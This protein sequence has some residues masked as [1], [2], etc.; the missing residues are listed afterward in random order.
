MMISFVYTRLQVHGIQYIKMPHRFIITIVIADIA[1]YTVDSTLQ[2][3]V[4]R[5]DNWFGKTND[6]DRL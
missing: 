4:Q 6:I 3:N 1:A 2:I 5:D